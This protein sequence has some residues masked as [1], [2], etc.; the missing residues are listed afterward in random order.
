MNDSTLRL[1]CSGV[2]TLALLAMVGL[3]LILLSGGG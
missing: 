1:V 2:V 3:W